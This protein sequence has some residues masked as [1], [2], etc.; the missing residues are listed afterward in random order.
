MARAFAT[1]AVT[2]GSIAYIVWKVDLHETIDVLRSVDPAW[3]VGALAILVAAVPVLAWRWQVL[4]R[5]R[6]VHDSVG[7]LTRTSFVSNTAAQVLPTSLGGDAMRIFETARRHP[8]ARGAVAATVLLERGLGGFATLALGAVGFVLAV[9]RYD[10]GA[11]LWLEAVLAL[12]GVVLAFA[13]FSRSA[14]R[15][16]RRLEPPLRRLRVAGPL[17]A[18]Y[19]EIHAFRERPRLMAWLLG[20]TIVVQ[21]TRILTIWMAGRAAGVDL[22]PLPYYVMGPL[23]FLVMLAPFTL[24]GFALREAF[25]VSFLG[26]A[27]VD[28]NAAFTTGLLYMVLS[29]LLAVPGALI[30]GF[31]GHQR[32]WIELVPVL[33]HLP[34]AQPE[35][36]DLLDRVALV[37]RGHAH[38]LAHVGSRSWSAVRRRGRLRRSGRPR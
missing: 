9:G 27:G 21:A 6:G 28:P 29:L 22:S 37:R 26:A 35:D 38:E 10:V 24:N 1:L 15:L 3:L 11:Y 13:L 14:R 17:K 36:V 7:W 19:E 30:W 18:V 34:V 5:A 31:E 32:E 25:F 23:F 16:L 12:G 20:L 8:D 2:V 33:D 4:L